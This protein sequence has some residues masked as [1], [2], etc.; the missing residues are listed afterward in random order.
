MNEV[1]EIVCAICLHRPHDIQEYIDAAVE[2]DMSTDEYVAREEG[3]YNK[4]SRK[5]YCTA[6]YI[7]LGM[8]LGTAP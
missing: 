8:P 5:F 2:F 6:C 7:R 1:P 3:T 4:R